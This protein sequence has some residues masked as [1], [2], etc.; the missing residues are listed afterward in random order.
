MES[1]HPPAKI[2]RTTP[3]WL[4]TK[5]KPLIEIGNQDLVPSTLTQNDPSVLVT[6]ASQGSSSTTLQSLAE[7]VGQLKATVASLVEVVHTLTRNRG[8][9]GWL[10]QGQVGTPLVV[11]N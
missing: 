4:A 3:A 5:Q 6:D 8:V 2:S 9:G 1:T 10:S 7:D 11:G